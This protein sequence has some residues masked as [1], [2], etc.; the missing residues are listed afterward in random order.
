MVYNV[1]CSNS[2]DAVCDCESGYKCN[3]K[4]CT[5]CEKIP[6]PPPPTTTTTTTPPASNTT[7]TTTTSS[8]M[9]IILSHG[10]FWGSK[11]TSAESSQCT[12]DEEVPMPV[13]EVCG[14]KEW[15]E[16]V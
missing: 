15:Q 1:S 6:T 12:E 10:S 11:K 4:S 13:Q 8:V 3:D 14:Q 2:N 7:R 16:E 5:Q 9:P